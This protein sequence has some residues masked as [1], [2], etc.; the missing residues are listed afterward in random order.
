MTFAVGPEGLTVLELDGS[1]VSDEE[2]PE[3]QAEEQ[4]INPNESFTDAVNRQL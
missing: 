4:P 2:A 3:E 1:P